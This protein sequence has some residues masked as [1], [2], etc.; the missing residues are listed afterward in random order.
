[1]HTKKK[2]EKV[3]KDITYLPKIKTKKTLLPVIK[4]V[5]ELEES[6]ATIENVDE[7][8]NQTI[9]LHE[10]DALRFASLSQEAAN[11]PDAAKSPLD[12]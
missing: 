4:E 1:M 5:K 11:S 6:K 12:I 7:M 8:P 9:L 10:L 3:I 2:A